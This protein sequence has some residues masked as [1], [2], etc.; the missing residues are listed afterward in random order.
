MKEIFISSD[1]KYDAR[2]SELAVNDLQE[3]DLT[4][5][6]IICCPSIEEESNILEI[7]FSGY[8]F[9]LNN[10]YNIRLSRDCNFEFNARIKLCVPNGLKLTS[11]CII[12]GLYCIQ[13]QYETTSGVILKDYQI[14]PTLNNL[15]LYANNN[16]YTFYN[17]VNFILKEYNRDMFTKYAM[18]KFKTTT[19]IDANTPIIE[20]YFIT[21]FIGD[22]YNP[23]YNQVYIIH[24]DYIYRN[25]PDLGGFK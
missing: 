9:K 1:N 4:K 6:V 5:D 11:E 20:I 3:I 15:I 24:S 18:N 14:I 8:Q 22:G 25:L 7:E 10:M 17:K 21:T 2:Q 19:R 16:D 12:P 13:N 23:K